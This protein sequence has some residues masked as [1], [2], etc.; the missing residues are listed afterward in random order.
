MLLIAA[1][2]GI[3]RNLHEAL[4]GHADLDA[5]AS[6][7]EMDIDRSSLLRHARLFLP[8]ALRQPFRDWLRMQ[9]TG[10]SASLQIIEAA[11]RP[12][13]GAALTLIAMSCADPAAAASSRPGEGMRVDVMLSGDPAAAIVD[14]PLDRMIRR[15]AAKLPSSKRLRNCACP[16]APAPTRVER[17]AQRVRPHLSRSHPAVLAGIYAC[18]GASPA[19]RRGPARRRG[20]CA[21]DAPTSLPAHCVPDRPR[22]LTRQRAI[23]GDT[24]AATL[25]AVVDTWPAR[26]TWPMP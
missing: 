20:C 16:A 14:A 22:F 21:F 10:S 9:S 8:P 23:G 15:G 6:V 1:T 17:W 12:V 26:S 18:A 4:F 7:A 5:S 13:D 3:R 19:S 2:P 24:H 11:D 25:R